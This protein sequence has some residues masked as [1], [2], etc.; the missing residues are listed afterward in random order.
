MKLAKRSAL[1]VI[2]CAASLGFTTPTQAQRFPDYKAHNEWGPTDAEVSQLPPYCQV[3]FRPQ[4]YRALSLE[5]YKCGP[6]FNHYCP[7]LVALKRAM[8]PLGTKQQRR[9]I[10]G[11][12]QK[13]LSG[14]RAKMTP[15]C[16]LASEVIGA[17][18]QAKMLGSLIK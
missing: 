15:S 17:E 11:I 1:L 3:Q 14:V 7:G 12:A 18:Q 4:Q 5:S 13:T 2:A 16:S 6:N 8:N 10:L 9:Q